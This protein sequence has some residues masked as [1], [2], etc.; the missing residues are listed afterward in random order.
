MS[1]VVSPA[2]S[3]PRSAACRS[4]VLLL[5]AVGV[6]A[7]A[8]DAAHA[9]DPG[10][11]PATTWCI[12]RTDQQQPEC[13]YDNLVTCGMNAI[14]KGGQCAKAEWTVPPTATPATTTAAVPQRP[15]RKPPQRKL[16]TAEQND[17]LFREFERWKESG[18]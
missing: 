12:V 10:A 18:K 16:T 7:M 9:N 8:A 4:F 3:H 14:L 11:T 2:N 5:G 13:V 1:C 15:R 6:V 17:K